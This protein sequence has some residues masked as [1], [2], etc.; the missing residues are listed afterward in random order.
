[1]EFCFPPMFNILRFEL[2]IYSILTGVFFHLYF[3]K[4][5]EIKYLHLAI[6][7]MTCSHD[8]LIHGQTN[9]HSYRHKQI[10]QT[11]VLILQFSPV[12]CCKKIKHIWKISKSVLNIVGVLT[13]R[14]CQS[15]TR[16]SRLA[17]NCSAGFRRSQ[18]TKGFMPLTVS[19]LGCAPF[20]LCGD[21]LAIE[22][23]PLGQGLHVVPL[24][25]IAVTTGIATFFGAVIPCPIDVC[26]S[27]VIICLHKPICST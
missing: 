1:M 18:N 3:I 14:L 16:R 27:R 6:S 2:H 24:T 23:F 20:F 21:V 11:M 19:G 22:M 17:A 13:S 9:I 25:A 15:I 10:E 8:L 12:I 4:P 5:R 7:Y 26:C